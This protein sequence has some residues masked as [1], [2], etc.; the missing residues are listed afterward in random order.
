VSLPFSEAELL[1]DQIESFF[2]MRQHC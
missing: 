2:P 1:L